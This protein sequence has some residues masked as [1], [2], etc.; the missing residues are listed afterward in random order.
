HTFDRLKDVSLERLVVDRLGTERLVNRD[1]VAID[2]IRTSSLIFRISTGFSRYFGVNASFPAVRATPRW[3]NY[4]AAEAFAN[5][6]FSARDVG[7]SSITDM[8]FQRPRRKRNIIVKPPIMMAP[9]QR[10]Q[11]SVREFLPRAS[12]IA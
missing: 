11:L 9:V 8:D 1:L 2:M 3:S 7:M 12:A 6:G 4:F 10:L 5:K